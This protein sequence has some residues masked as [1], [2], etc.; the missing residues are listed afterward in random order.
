MHAHL[1]IAI[2]AVRSAGNILLRNFEY[3]E[4]HKAQE[5]G[6]NDLVTFVD[7]SAE[8]E[9]INTILKAYPDHAI[10]GEENGAIGNGDY[11]WIIDPI[12]GTLNYVHGIPQFAISLALKYK[13]VVEQGVIYNPV[14]QELYSAS[15]GRGAQLNGRRI[16]CSGLTS[17]K[18]AVIGAGLPERN[19]DCLDACL[20]TLKELIINGAVIRRFGS[21]ALNLAYVASGKLDGFWAI[22][23]NEWDIAAG[24]LLVREAGGFLGDFAGET[25][26]MQNGQILAASPKIYTYLLK[27]FQEQGLPF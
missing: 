18:S 3:P 22:G 16:R 26:G 9:I 27:I 4:T 19:L 14:T 7:Q 25:K 17:I 20:N 10:L 6:H 21:A 23:I 5:K 12:D 13:G 15:K 24:G 2:K 8:E 11:V 1:N